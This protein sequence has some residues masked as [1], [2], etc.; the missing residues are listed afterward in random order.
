VRGVSELLADGAPLPGHRRILSHAQLL[1]IKVI[2]IIDGTR[3]RSIQD[4]GE[5][6]PTLSFCK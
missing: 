2:G 4:T 3:L 5:S 1:K 6:F